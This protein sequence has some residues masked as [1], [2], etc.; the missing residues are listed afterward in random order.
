MI[1]I[2]LHTLLHT[3][4]DTAKLLPFLFLTYLLM[5]YLEHRADGATERLLRGSGRVGPLVGSLLGAVPQCG[6]SAAAS[7]LY[8]GR[9]LTTGTLIAV[10]LSTSDEMLPIM[11]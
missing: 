9:I 1:E 5:E 11:I 10:Y 4:L 2:L 7:G 6:F 3:L 8:A